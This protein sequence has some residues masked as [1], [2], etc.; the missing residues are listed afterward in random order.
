M[1]DDGATSA[2]QNPYIL[3]PMPG[4]ESRVSTDHPRMLDARVL[5][6]LVIEPVCHGGRDLG[7]IISIRKAAGYCPVTVVT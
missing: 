6:L 1:G 5:I 4:S 7:F 3:Q 2:N